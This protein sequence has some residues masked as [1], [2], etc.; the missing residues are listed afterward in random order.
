MSVF[1]PPTGVSCVGSASFP[2]HFLPNLVASLVQFRG[3]TSGLVKKTK[4][5]VAVFR[6]VILAA[7][8]T[9]NQLRAD[10]PALVPTW[11]VRAVRATFRDRDADNPNQPLLIPSLPS[12]LPSAVEEDSISRKFP[13]LFSGL[14]VLRRPPSRQ[15]GPASQSATEGRASAVGSGK[16][17]IGTNQLRTSPCSSRVEDCYCLGTNSSK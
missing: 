6:G 14:F 5:G 10:I 9:N 2:I 3:H 4:G 16:I 1:S 17:E 12:F 8:A 13:L 7:N 15:A 11:L